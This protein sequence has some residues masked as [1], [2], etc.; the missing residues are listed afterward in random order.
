MRYEKPVG[1]QPASR[2]SEN[3]M[4]LAIIIAVAEY[5]KPV[6]SLPACI[7]DATLMKKLLD[8]TQQYA[9][10]LYLS[11]KVLSADAKAQVAQFVHR[12]ANESVDGDFLL[13]LRSRRPAWR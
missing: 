8:A 2:F 5:A 1:I 4:K 12:Y 9:D 10:V 6:E 3:R 7:N 13:L 11:G